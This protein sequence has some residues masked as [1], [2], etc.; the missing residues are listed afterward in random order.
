MSP[1]AAR[2]PRLLR[3]DRAALT[4]APGVRRAAAEGTYSGNQSPL[5]GETVTGTR[6]WASLTQPRDCQQDREQHDEEAAAPLQG[7]RGFACD[8][9]AARPPPGSPSFPI[10]VALCWHLS[11][12][13]ALLPTLVSS[14]HGRG[15]SWAS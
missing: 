1:V 5:S 6:D 13:I 14:G 9:I 11:V 7:A 15:D 12:V 10:P 4:P 8:S 2:P 3:E